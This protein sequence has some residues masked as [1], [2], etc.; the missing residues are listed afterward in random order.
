M[1]VHKL[2]QRPDADNLALAVGA[3]GPTMAKDAGYQLYCP[4]LFD[5]FDLPATWLDVLS[6]EQLSIAFYPRNKTD[7]AGDAVDNT[8]STITF[9]D[10]DL[11]LYYVL[12]TPERHNMMLD[13]K[14]PG[15]ASFN[16]IGF[17]HFAESRY[18]QAATETLVRIQMYCGSPIYRTVIAIREVPD[19]GA[20]FG[21][22]FGSIF[23]P[24]STNLTSIKISDSGSTLYESN[25][26]ECLMEN[27]VT[28]KSSYIVINWGLLNEL[29]PDQKRSIT[30]VSVIHVTLMCTIRL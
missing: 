1:I 13:A 10:A 5:M 24:L 27:G 16:Y 8:V 15:G 19:A 17:N 18:T 11:L 29:D 12:P 30:A 6:L 7:W 22:T 9:L 25:A 28:I 2:L 23:A 26:V 20:A 21:K 3:A 14:H 4:L